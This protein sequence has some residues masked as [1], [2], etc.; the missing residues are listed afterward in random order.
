MSNLF[1]YLQ[2][3]PAL[4]T[5]GRQSFGMISSDEFRITT[6]FALTAETKAYAMMSG[7]LLFQQQTTDPDKVNIILRPSNPSVFKLPIKYV[8]YRGLKR[9]NFLDLNLLTDPLN[10]VKTTGNELVVKMKALQDG[11]SPGDDIPVEAL[12]GYNLSPAGTDTIREF[13]FKKTLIASSLFTIEGGIEL[14]NFA[15]GNAG[16]EIVLE[17]PT[18]DL[19]VS[20]AKLEELIINVSLDSLTD[21]KAKREKIGHFIDPVAFYGLHAGIKGGIGYKDSVGALQNANTSAL[22]FTHIQSQFVNKS[23]VYLDIRNENG[24]SYNY[25]DNYV[26]TAGS[27]AQNSKELK[28]G[29]SIGSLTLKEYYQSEW[30][31]HIVDVITPSGT[32]AENIFY[33]SLRVNDNE[34]PLIS[35]HINNISPEVV[36]DKDTIFIDESVLL[37]API[38]ATLPEFTNPI[39]VKVPNISGS[40]PE[41]PATYIRLDYFKQ[42]LPLSTSTKFPTIKFSDYLFGPLNISVPFDSGNNVQ[43]INSFRR[44]F[45]DSINDGYVLGQMKTPITGF[46]STSKIEIFGEIPVHT[47]TDLI[48]ENDNGITT[49]EGTFEILGVTINAGITTIELNGTL[50]GILESGDNAVIAIHVDG[51]MDFAK[52]SFTI[53]NGD[54]SALG[55]LAIG[56]ELDFYSKYSFASTYTVAT[57]SYVNPNTVIVF[58]ETTKKSG[59]AA[60]M[61]TGI[62]LESDLASGSPTD[63]DRLMYYASPVG[64]YQ[65]KKVKKS[66]SFA[67]SGGTSEIDSILKVLEKIIPGV[68]IS[69]TKLKPNS[70][71][72]ALTFHYQTNSKVKE[73]LF[74]LGIT[75]TEFQSMST[76]VFN[77]AHQILMRLTPDGGRKTD[78]NGN[79]YYAFEI[80]LAGL[81]SSLTYIEQSTGIIVYSTDNLIFTSAAFSARYGIDTTLAAQ[82]VNDFLTNYD[83]TGIKNFTYEEDN[84]LNQNNSYGPKNKTLLEK[85]PTM[86]LKVSDFKTALDNVAANKSAIINLLKQLGED[87]LSHYKQRIKMPGESFTNK[88]GILYIARLR[89][90]VIMKNHPVIISNFPSQIRKFYNIFELHSRGL[91]G[92]EKPNFASTPSGVKKIL[93][94]GFDPFNIGGGNIGLDWDEE[95]SN[96]SGNIALSISNRAIYE[97][98]DPFTDTNSTGNK[99]DV[100]CAIFPVRWEDFDNGVAED[101]FNPYFSGANKPDMIITYSYGVHYDSSIDHDFHLE[102]FA[103]NW[104]SYANDNNGSEMYDRSPRQ[105]TGKPAIIWPLKPSRKDWTFI[106][107]K[108]PFEKLEDPYNPGH[109]KVPNYHVVVNHG[110]KTQNYDRYRFGIYWDIFG[111]SGGVETNVSSIADSAVGGN[112]SIYFPNKPFLPIVNSQSSF[113]SN[114]NTNLAILFNRFLVCDNTKISYFDPVDNTPT[115]TTNDQYIPLPTWENYKIPAID[116]AFTNVRIEARNGSGGTYMSNLIFYRVAYMRMENGNNIPTG[117]IHMGFN[118]E[119]GL[120]PNYD[121]HGANSTNREGMLKDVAFMLQR[122]NDISTD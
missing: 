15:S 69:S 64:Y 35:S 54:Y 43:W 32:L 77:S 52:N 26:G 113:N 13:F 27:T 3:D 20:E 121:P 119:A 61:E 65:S 63:D 42:N 50:S 45:V 40:S 51:E 72:D 118:K 74:L 31:L 1:H 44:T 117:H 28:I 104:Q 112:P 22:V 38:P 19:T 66:R 111:T 60:I 94:T 5:T 99:I 97:G 84:M 30:P 58:S 29:D 107:S 86:V 37:P 48:I 120:L 41:Q 109:I 56:K 93:I 70:T 115:R 102:R 88:D 114:K 55:A 76:S 49:N 116:L 62:I 92:T 24:Y 105:N 18:Y 39:T 17:N 100:Q 95:V 47:E 25:Y 79:S 80:K 98:T 12:F 33:V 57:N 67:N 96:P 71:T 89:M 10:K 2:A 78:L 9:D 87:L 6:S 108:L 68:Q 11:R 14:G 34:R 23:T 83:F 75:K 36:K 46:V 7:T 91:A 90:Q 4:P 73:M 81:D 122:F 101:F 103:S 8:I 110:P 59:F 82:A 16:I 21:K 85:D 53:K 106:E